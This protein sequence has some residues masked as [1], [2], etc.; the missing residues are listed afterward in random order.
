MVVKQ[1]G[2]PACKETDSNYQS[3]KVLFENKWKKQIKTTT[4]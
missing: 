3:I 2:R 1:G 4:C